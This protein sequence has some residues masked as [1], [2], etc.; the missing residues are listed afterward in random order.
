MAHNDFTLGALVRLSINITQGGTLVDPSE[1]T[2]TV[3]EPDGTEITTNTAG[4]VVQEST[5]VYYYDYDAQKSGA[6]EY[7][8]V[9]TAPQGAIEGYFSVLPSRIDTLNP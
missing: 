9:T 2:I 4:N 7:R 8:W 3:E 5:G 6:C 1:V